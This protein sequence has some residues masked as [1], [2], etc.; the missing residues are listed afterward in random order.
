MAIPE[1]KNPFPNSAYFYDGYL[2]APDFSLKLI[3]IKGIYDPDDPW[4]FNEWLR[5]RTSEIDNFLLDK[6]TGRTAF[7][8]NPKF[9][10]QL[11]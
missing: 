6:Y 2:Y 11:P 1:N 10:D 4:G 8:K 3:C 9:L 7:E 5:R